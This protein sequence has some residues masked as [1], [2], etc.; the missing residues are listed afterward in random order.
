MDIEVPD[1]PKDPGRGSHNILLGPLLYIER[2]DFLEGGHKEFRRLTPHQPV[3]LKYTSSTITVQ[4][5]IKVP[6]Q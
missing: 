2:S 5:V 6:I 3:G 1:F 4:N